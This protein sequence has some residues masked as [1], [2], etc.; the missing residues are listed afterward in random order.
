MA[1][2]CNDEKSQITLGEFVKDNKIDF[3]IMGALLKRMPPEVYH[4]FA[5]GMVSTSIAFQRLVE[6]IAQERYSVICKNHVLNDLYLESD[7]FQTSL[8]NPKSGISEIASERKRQI[9]EE[10]WT[11]EH[12]AKHDPGAI[13]KEMI[14]TSSV[15][16]D[17]E[18]NGTGRLDVGSKLAIEQAISGMMTEHERIVS[19]LRAEIDRL[20]AQQDG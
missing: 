15:V 13:A 9:E 7:L 10:G 8:K 6:Q 3:E 17:R 5:K 2:C 19:C 12:D 4:E 11:A 1:K 18:L 14:D 20:K 16:L